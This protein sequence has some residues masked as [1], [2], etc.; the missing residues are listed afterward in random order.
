M[1]T[2]TQ[3]INSVKFIDGII[4][5]NTEG[6]THKDS[7]RQLTFPGNCMNW[8]LGHL[9]VY[10]MQ[11]LGVIDGNSQPDE[12][13][14]AIYGA[15]SKPLMDGDKAIPLETLLTRLDAASEQVISA[16]QSMPS[17]K[18][19]EMYDQEQ[20]TTVDDRLNFY[21]VFHEAYHAGQLEIL[22]ELALAHK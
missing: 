7:M 15:G 1:P 21:L 22:R 3:Y 17:E 10:R 20:G 9:L 11:Y 18:L 14:Y 4:K 19:A 13:E 16:L 12:K 8:N 5:S 6:L 2:L